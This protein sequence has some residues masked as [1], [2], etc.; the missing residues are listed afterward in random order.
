MELWVQKTW[1]FQCR[2][3]HCGLHQEGAPEH[4]ILKILF[5]EMHIGHNP[6]NTIAILLKFLVT[7]FVVDDQVN[8]QGS[9]DPNSKTR[10]IN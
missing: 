2:V 10:N 9:A 5:G 1:I 7:E 4:P 8:D 6:V 3:F